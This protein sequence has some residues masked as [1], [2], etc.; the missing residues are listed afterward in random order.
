[1]PTVAILVGERATEDRLARAWVPVHE[2]SHLATPFIDRRDAWLS[3][4]IATYY[5]EILRARAG[6]LRPEDA[7]A[8][9][10]DGFERGARD[11]TGRTLAEE[12]R[13]MMETAAFRRVY[14]AGAAIAL[15]AD[16]EMRMRSNGQR[17]LD[18]ALAALHA[19]CSGRLTPMSA[20]EAM[21]QMDGDGPP[22]FASIARRVLASREWP[23]LASTLAALGIQRTSA[24][25]TF[26]QENA[27]A[28]ALRE[29]IVAP[30]SDL[31]ASPERCSAI[32]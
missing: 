1:M 12:S 10:F 4:G 6:I 5:Q 21:Q 16:V 9:L 8:N 20:E 17:T 15:M 29:A 13:D 27:R 3:E 28:R 22:I 7:W 14:W 23:D 26:D 18:D 2:F 30:R 32:H 25:V 11:G 19:C 24:G 31:V